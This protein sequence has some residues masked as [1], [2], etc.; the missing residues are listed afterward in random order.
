M[1]GTI[2]TIPVYPGSGISGVVEGAIIISNGEIVGLAS[3]YDP[4]DTNL[5]GH[6][7][8]GRARLQKLRNFGF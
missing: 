4:L 7:D 8:H 1:T 5:N 6:V 2:Q 3:K